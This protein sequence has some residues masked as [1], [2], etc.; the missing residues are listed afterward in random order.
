MAQISAQKRAYTDVTKLLLNKHEVWMM[1]TNEYFVKFLGPKETPYEGGV[2]KVRILIPSNYP[3]S[4]PSV[5][6]VN[7]IFHPNVEETSGAVC[8]DVINQTWSPLYDLSN[9]FE[10]FL[11]QLLTYPN[12]RDPLNPEAATL[13]LFD[14]ATFLKRVKLYVKKY[15]NIVRLEEESEEVDSSGAE[16]SSMSEREDDQ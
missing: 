15:A 2:W 8:L 4:S 9:I 1:N 3:F 12:S 10:V 14:N 16:D 13:C 6:F 7:K 11:P 5:S